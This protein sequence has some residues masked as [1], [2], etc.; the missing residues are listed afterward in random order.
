VKPLLLAL[1]AVSAVAAPRT[2]AL[3]PTSRT[4]QGEVA[5]VEP[6]HK[7]FTVRTVKTPAGFTVSWGPQTNFIRGEKSA[8]PDSLKRGQQVTVRYR[9]PFFSPR[10]AS[11]V[12]ILSHKN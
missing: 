7:R 8:T 11:R 5:A 1:L 9:T 3:P 10:I 2:S 12:F 4:L 6:E